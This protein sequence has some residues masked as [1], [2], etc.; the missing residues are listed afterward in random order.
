MQDLTE[1]WPKVTFPVNGEGSITVTLEDPEG[2]EWAGL[3]Y[4][5]RGLR[6]LL[7]S[8]DKIKALNKIQ[9]GDHLTFS[10]AAEKLRKYKFYIVRK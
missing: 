4:E 8:W 1:C 9:P 10:A 6:A 3:Y 7:A 5:N 2:R